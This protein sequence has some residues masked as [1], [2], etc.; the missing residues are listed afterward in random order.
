M[1]QETMCTYYLYKMS[2][3]LKR[4]FFHVFQKKSTSSFSYQGFLLTYVNHFRYLQN[5]CTVQAFHGK[6]PSMKEA[7]DFQTV[8]LY[9]V[10]VIFSDKDISFP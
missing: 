5:A 8:R 3:V 10:S 6:L 2:I 7:V 9:V 1:K 4:Y